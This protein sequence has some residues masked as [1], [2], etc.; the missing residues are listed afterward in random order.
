MGDSAIQG[1]IQTLIQADSAFAS[2][3][4][5]LGDFRVLDSGGPPYAVIL[6]GAIVEARR[7][8]DWSQ[9]QFFWEHE[10]DVFERFLGDSYTSFVTARQTVVDIIA[11]NP[12]LGGNAGISN[13]LVTRATAPLYVYPE[14]GADVPTFVLSKLTVRTVEE[15]L[16]AGAGEF[17]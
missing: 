2:A 6:P 7:S 12:T 8:G 15:V 17:A 16:Y 1:Y 9:V 3:D 4:V 10:V 14:A 5:T 11:R 13:T